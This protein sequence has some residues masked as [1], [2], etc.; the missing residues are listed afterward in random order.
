MKKK[1]RKKIDYIIVILF[2]LCILVLLIDFTY[3]GRINC[4][5]FLDKTFWLGNLLSSIGFQRCIAM[6]F[7]Q[8]GAGMAL[9]V[10][11]IV[12]NMGNNLFIHSER[13]VFGLSLGDL[14]SDQSWI[15]R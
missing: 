7:L 5:F 10:M 6:T 9:T 12:L 14:R 8:S 11:T 13:K 2:L 3:A 15:Y 1:V 4:N